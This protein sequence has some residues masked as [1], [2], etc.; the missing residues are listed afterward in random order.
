MCGII[1]YLGTRA[2]SGL[3][4]EGLSKLEYRGY[5]SAGVAILEASGEAWR[6]HRVRAAGKR[7]DALLH[8]V[9]FHGPAHRLELEVQDIPVDLPADGAGG[10][11]GWL[12]W[13]LNRFYPSRPMRRGR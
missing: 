4:L 7:R 5:D 6:T 3:L 1:G 8:H 12:P 11:S 2:A 9:R 13:F 10:Q